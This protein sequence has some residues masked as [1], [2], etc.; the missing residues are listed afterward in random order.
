[1]FYVNPI[2]GSL[3][4]GIPRQ[5]F[6]ELTVQGF[7]RQGGCP[8][9]KVRLLEDHRTHAALVERVLRFEERV[10]GWNRTN[11]DRRDAVGLVREMDAGFVRRVNGL[12]HLL[13]QRQVAAHQ[14]V[15]VSALR[16]NAL[17]SNMDPT[18]LQVWRSRR[19]SNP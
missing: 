19:D 6:S 17:Q 16:H 18:E 9:S 15:E 11:D 10:F 2:L 14:H 13:R 7:R 8:V 12:T 3:P 4:E 1:M 5:E